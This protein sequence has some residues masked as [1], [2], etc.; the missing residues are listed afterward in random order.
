MLNQQGSVII[1]VLLI[2]V[3]L[4]VLAAAISFMTYQHLDRSIGREQHTQAYYMAEG[5]LVRAKTMVENGYAVPGGERVMI[6]ENEFLSDPHFDGLAHHVTIRPKGDGSYLVVS[7]GR[8]YPREKPQA[9]S[10]ID[11]YDLMM[12]VVPLPAYPGIESPLVRHSVFSP[13]NLLTIKQTGNFSMEVRGSQTERARIYVDGEIDFSGSPHD[14]P[15]WFVDLYASR[16]IK[17]DSKLKEQL[18]QQGTKLY[19]YTTPTDVTPY[20]MEE[21]IAQVEQM[22]ENLDPDVKVFANGEQPDLEDTDETILFLQDWGEDL[23]LQNITI[24]SEEEPK[25]VVVSMQPGTEVNF[26]GKVTI[27]GHIVINSTANVVGDNHNKT[28]NLKI[29]GGIA[30]NQLN[31]GNHAD[32]SIIHK[33]GGGGFSYL[34]QEG[35][36]SGQ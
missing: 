22:A 33:D 17:A 21:L 26:K 3:L 23:T 25:L 36:E 20:M 29:I 6:D 1:S 31:L 32:V 28:V 9:G 14:V 7:S 8:V 18:L 2:V 5:G 4:S 24:G 16:D 12:R 13:Q 19:P 34:Y 30:A 35:G 11:H 27:Y 15:L 10:Y